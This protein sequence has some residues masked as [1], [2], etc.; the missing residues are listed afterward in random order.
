MKIIKEMTR[1]G[2]PIYAYYIPHAKSVSVTVVVK[3]GTR[4][5]LWPKEAGLAHAMEHMVFRGT[6]DFPKEKDLSFFIEHIGGS[7]NAWTSKECTKYKSC[8]PS[9]SI[10]KAIY[11]LS[12]LVRRPLFREKDI[13]IEMKVVVQELMADNDSPDEQTRV[14][15]I[16]GIFG[17]HPLAFETAGLKSSILNFKKVDF[18]RW[19]RNFYCPE[20][21]AFF[22]IGNF[23]ISELKKL[24]E[25]YFPENIR[26][27]SQNKF[28]LAPQPIKK[29][30]HFI[31]NTRQ[32][33]INFGA[34]TPEA[35]HPDNLPLDIFDMMIAGGMSSPL[36]QEIRGKRGLAYSVNA[37]NFMYKET[38]FFVTE[39]ET[40]PH[41]AEEAIKASLEVIKRSKDSSALMNTAKE[42]SIGQLKIVSDSYEDF[43]DMAINDFNVFGR[44]VSIEEKISK[45]KA[46]TIKQIS[47]AVEKYL[48]DESRRV[49]VILGPK[50][51]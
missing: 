7:I 8:V 33:Y 16:K 39:I 27:K 38:G 29:S 51:K 22:V 31:R 12:Q 46:V 6:E 48:L 9:T 3:A 18:K 25:K 2:V 28:I 10:N 1:Q 19:Q 26:S 41:K 50:N 49:T 11:A 30:L 24:L 32:T 45:I 34:I 4:N 42:M 36:F 21:L 17:K 37:I 14:E 23:N 35:G 5:E 47:Q 13:R 44:V 15:Y 43:L 40:D 20:N